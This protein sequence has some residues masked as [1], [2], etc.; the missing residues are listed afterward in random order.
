MSATEALRYDYLG[1][2]YPFHEVEQYP[3][4]SDGVDGSRISSRRRWF[5]VG[6]RANCL[7]RSSWRRWRL[8]VCSP[9]VFL[10]SKLI[11][12]AEWSWWWIDN[13][14]PRMPRTVTRLDLHSYYITQGWRIASCWCQE[15]ITKCSNELE[16]STQRPAWLVYGRFNPPVLDEG[17]PWHHCASQAQSLCHLQCLMNHNPHPA[18]SPSELTIQRFQSSL[19]EYRT[20]ENWVVPRRV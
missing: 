9:W 4:L 10:S 5:Q 12:Y 2:R 16:I 19:T 15:K 17:S 14:E 20:T 1:Y 7:C 3:S 13:N 18:A 8:G 11:Q 6:C